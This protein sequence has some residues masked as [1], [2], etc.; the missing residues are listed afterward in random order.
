MALWH[1]WFVVPLQPWLM[2]W[3]EGSD[4]QCDYGSKKDS[5]AIPKFVFTWFQLS[6]GHSCVSGGTDSA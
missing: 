4:A 5:E 2:F 3:G 6:W 1:R